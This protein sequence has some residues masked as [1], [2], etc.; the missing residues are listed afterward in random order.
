ME[1]RANEDLSGCRLFDREKAATYLSITSKSLHRL[2][3]KGV[4]T[5]VQLPEFRR[6]LFDK[7]DLDDLI[8]THKARLN[9]GCQ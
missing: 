3:Q 4:L 1:M 6:V 5:P 2:V 8:E 9:E 7:Q